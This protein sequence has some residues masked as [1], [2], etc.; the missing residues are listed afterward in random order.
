[1]SLSAMRLLRC[2]ARDGRS[3][4]RAVLGSAYAS[5]EPLADSVN[6]AG[7]DDESSGGRELLSL[8][9]SQHPD[10]DGRGCERHERATWRVKRLA[11]H[12]DIACPQAQ[13]PQTTNEVEQQ[14]AGTPDDHELTKRP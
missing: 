6:G 7:H 1:M 5:P 8:E 4:S 2:C 13:E 10:N 9:R 11:C 14:S 3:P 12:R